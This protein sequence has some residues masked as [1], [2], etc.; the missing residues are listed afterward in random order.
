LAIESVR[1]AYGH[2]AIVAAIGRTLWEDKAE[3]QAIS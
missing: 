3:W 1:F 2:E